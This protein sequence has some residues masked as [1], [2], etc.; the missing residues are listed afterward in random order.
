[1]VQFV[2]PLRNP[3]ACSILSGLLLVLSFPDYAMNLV[4]WFALAPLFAVCAQPHGRWRLFLFGYLTGLTFFAGSTYWIYDVMRLYGQLSFTAAVWVFVVFVLAF[5]VFVAVFALLAGEM[6]RR[7]HVNALFLFPFLWVAVEWARTYIP[8]GGFPWNLLGYAI[9]PYPGWIQP[10][11]YTGVYGL[12]FILATVSAAVAGFWLSPSR[13]RG[14]AL[15]VVAGLLLVTALLGMQLPPE[16]TNRRAVLVQPNLEQTLSPEPNWARNN[17]AELD[18][19][20][21]L[22]RE[23]V[24]SLES[25][26]VPLV[27]WPEMPV[28]LYF[29]R[30]PVLRARFVR[31]AQGMRSYFLSGI[32]DFR[33]ARKNRRGNLKD[34][35]EEKLYPYNSAVL[36]APGGA[37]V[38]QYDK[39]H[40]VPFGEYVPWA[41]VLALA[42]SLTQEISDFQPG[43]SYSVLPVGEDRLSVFICYES[44]FPGQIR[45]FV[46]R[47]ATVLVNVSNDG[48][49]GNSAA[50][51]QHLNM[52][53]VRAVE[54]GRFVLRATNTG[55]TAVVDPRGRILAQAPQRE[56]AVLTVGFAHR[57]GKTFF[58]RFGDWFPALCV[59]ITMAALVRNY[60]LQATEV[61]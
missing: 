31:M 47:G 1:M 61:T 3:F 48:W 35:A 55:L 42:G 54:T 16:P 38:G 13:R 32:V 43:N 50:A 46:V 30:D 58:V 39:I 59:M 7:W 12:S 25:E 60:W 52:A 10:A 56:R 53:R 49:F 44:I 17:K 2:S 40:L 57:R 41:N 6:A 26:S 22:S 37:L 9:G 27:V 33:P 45:E 5:A 51:P 11:S 23:A 8:F 19:L 18:A 4:A 15:A 28:S 29:N 20:E 34:Q 21:D 14:I 36:L 24:R